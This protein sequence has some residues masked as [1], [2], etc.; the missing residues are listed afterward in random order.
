MPARLALRLFYVRQKDF[1]LTGIALG[2]Y[3]TRV[4]FKS[5]LQ[6][7]SAAERKA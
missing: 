3:L 2:G 1:R 4:P 7:R 5:A 6:S